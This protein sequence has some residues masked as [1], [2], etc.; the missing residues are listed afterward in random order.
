MPHQCVRCSQIFADGAKQILTGCSCGAR[1]FFY[2]KK[3]HLEESKKVIQNLSKDQK[4]QIEEDIFE[5]SQVRKEDHVVE[6]D[7]PVVLDF[8]S[9]RVMKPGSYELDLIKMFKKNPLIFK[10]DE[11]KYMID[12]MQAFQNNKKD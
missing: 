11:G 10:L 6:E 3:K 8:E 9:I 2:I 7:K 4:K 1:L 5:I 12:I